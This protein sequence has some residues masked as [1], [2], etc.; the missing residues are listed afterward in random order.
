MLLQFLT[1]HTLSVS[2]VAQIP[3][4]IKLLFSCHVW[5]FFAFILCWHESQ[6]MLAEAEI[7]CICISE[8]VE[9][10]INENFEL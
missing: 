2:F 7:S 9:M 5:A 1:G 10:E 3:E 8:F 6:E 4:K